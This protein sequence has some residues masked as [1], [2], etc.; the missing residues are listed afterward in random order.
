[1]C[2]AGVPQVFRSPPYFDTWQPP[3]RTEI[4]DGLVR[5]G[6]PAIDIDNGDWKP[7]YNSNGWLVPNLTFPSPVVLPALF[8]LNEMRA[9]YTDTYADHKP[10]F[11]PYPLANLKSYGNFQSH[12]PMAYT[13]K[14]VDAINREINFLPFEGLTAP[15]IPAVIPGHSHGYNDSSHRYRDGAAY[16]EA[17]QAT[18]CAALGGNLR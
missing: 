10:S 9:L 8:D 17:Q 12:G 2:S 13:R 14:I 7:L 1:M 4:P 6:Y 11:F 15:P 3:L 18:L 16:H 5:S